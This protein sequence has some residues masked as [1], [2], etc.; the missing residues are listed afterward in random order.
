MIARCPPQSSWLKQLSWLRWLKYMYLKFNQIQWP[1][2]YYRKYNLYSFCFYT[3]RHTDRQTHSRFEI[4]Y[5]W[6]REKRKEMSVTTRNSELRV[7]IKLTERSPSF[8]WE[9]H[10]R[11]QSLAE[12]SIWNHSTQF[13]LG[14][15]FGSIANFDI[16]FVS[17]TLHMLLDVINS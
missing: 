13:V 9:Q 17:R 16:I 14:C 12:R 11:T 2:S 15:H 5:P 7:K 8:G 3:D 6:K 10:S 1:R 4:C